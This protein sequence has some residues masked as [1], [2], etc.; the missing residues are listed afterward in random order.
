MSE[1]PREKIFFEDGVLHAV[2][3]G[4]PLSFDRPGALLE[5]RLNCED[6]PESLKLGDGRDLLRA[7]FETV[8]FARGP[9]PEPFFGGGV[10][11]P[12]Q[13]AFKLFVNSNVAE[14]SDEFRVLAAEYGQFVVCARRWRDVWKAG[15]FTVEPRTVTVRFEDL[16]LRLPEKS[17]FTE[18]MVETVR[19]P[20][21]ADSP[22]LQSA[23]V[24]REVLPSI[25]PDARITV[26]ADAGGGFTLAFWPV[27]ARIG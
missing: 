23:H 7:A 6:A 21:A 25:A 12:A 11:L 5:S 19:D 3:A 16:W 24:V 14:K 17:R 4:T 10:T 15:C 18:Y 13:E 27:A 22:A 20:N 9:L 8:P 26:D 1:T 2:C